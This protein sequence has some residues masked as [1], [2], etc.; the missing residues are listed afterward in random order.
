M[1]LDEKR[2]IELEL[3][4]RNKTIKVYG[5]D[6]DGEIEIEVL[7]ESIWLCKEQVEQLIDYLSKQIS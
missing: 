3:E 1:I 6:K 5:L 4:T 7:D 2:K